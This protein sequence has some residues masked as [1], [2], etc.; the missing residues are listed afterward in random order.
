VTEEV[1]GVDIVQTQIKIAGGA[2]LRELGIGSQSD[3]PGPKGFAIQCRVT[4]EDPEQNFQVCSSTLLV[5]MTA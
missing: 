3:V 1:T 2:S 5:F 4:S